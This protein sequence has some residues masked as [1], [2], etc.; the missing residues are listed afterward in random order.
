MS[1]GALPKS[2]AAVWRLF[3]S[4]RVAATRISGFD[5]L[6]WVSRFKRSGWNPLLRMEL[7]VLLRPMVRLREPFHWP[8][9]GEPIPEESREPCIKDF[10][11]WE[12]VL[13]AGDHVHSPLEGLSRLPEWQ[14]ALVDLLPDLTGVLRD[15]CDLIHELGEADDKHD[16]SYSSQPS[17]G[18]HPQNTHYRE[19]AV[20]IELCR[21]AWLE[22]AAREP[23]KARIELRR[24]RGI[25]YPVFRRLS[26]FAA[27]NSPHVPADEGLTLLL[28][29]Q[30]WWL[31]SPETQ[32]EAIRLLVFL[33][34]KLEAKEAD[35]IFDAILLGPPLVM[36]KDDVEPDHL[37]RIIHHEV[38]L[39]LE[40]CLNAGGQLSASAELERQRIS[41]LHPEWKIEP[42]ERD[43][44][45]VWSGTGDEWR[46]RVVLPKLL[47]PLVKA[48][49]ERPKSDV[50]YEDD[51]RERCR[52]DS[53][54]AIHALLY[55]VKIGEWPGDTWREALQ[56]FADEKLFQSAW[57]YLSPKLLQAPE[58]FIA[59]VRHTLST[60]LQA[61][62]KHVDPDDNTFYLLVDRILDGAVNES[63]VENDDPVSRAINHPVG[64]ATEALIHLWYRMKPVDA[65]RYPPAIRMRFDRLVDHGVP[66][67]RH[68]RVLLCAHL[69]ALFRVDP[70]WTTMNL[71]PFFDWNKDKL[72][73]RAVWEGFLWAPRLYE[74]LIV[75]MKS[76]F[77]E[78]A[79]HYDDLGKHDTQYA[80]L[81]TL[82]ILEFKDVFSVNDLRSAFSKLPTKGVDASARFIV[83]ALR[84]AGN[85][86]ADYWQHRVK[87]FVAKIWPKS[88]AY[89]SASASVSLAQVCVAA[90]ESFSD[91]V[92][93][94]LELL[95]Q[96]ESYDLVVRDLAQTDICQRYPK[97]ALKL[98][99]AIVD[100]SE[101]HPPQ[102]LEKCLSDIG[103]YAPD[104][105]DT[106]AFRRLAEY[107]RK[108]G[109]T[110]L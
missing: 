37:Q 96:S 41:A 70:E 101:R 46:R 17:I 59:D 24:W 86:R 110:Q 50:W 105:R 28:S 82:S 5:F 62:S 99:D 4:N 67:Y 2:L 80:S 12:I 64:Q 74:P 102:E 87:P 76:F 13:R 23:E 11:D 10:V 51:W 8:V 54:R 48:L 40:K 27:A 90:G 47:K 25:A 39:R 78:T 61:A 69:V 9:A 71:L 75:S 43:E 73:A 42:D 56:V 106:K 89:R 88:A 57:K 72:E 36:F 45:P 49:L 14:A 26:F 95:V 98:L 30:A 91:A 107:L 85:K 3:L 63:S 77:L 34:P 84:D 108:Y 97:D 29:D 7:M 65:G 79:A 33:A 22:T 92:S 18:D 1:K 81:F 32:R 21:D 38:W 44:F 53:R 60:W 100:E 94:V 93:K 104:Q 103:Q 66:A 58:S 6:D 52:A 15:A 35:K 31:W 20:L 55:L 68:G 19:W 16:G 109:F 83:R